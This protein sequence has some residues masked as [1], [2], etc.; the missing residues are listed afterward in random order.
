MKTLLFLFL[1]CA[2]FAQEFTVTPAGLASK[3]DPSK[4]Y[5]VVH[6]EGVSADSLYASAKRYVQSKYTGPKD[7]IKGEL[8]SQFI[9]FE[10]TSDTIM[11]VKEKNKTVAYN[12]T[13]TTTID[14][15]DGKI[16]IS[17]PA[18]D[19]YTLN[20]SGEKEAYP[21]SAYWNKSGKLVN[22]RSKKLVEAYFNAFT[23]SLIK[24]VNSG[25]NKSQIGSAEW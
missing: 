9:S 1:S 10:T 5:V 14:F 11:S 20:K 6:F 23:G 13:Y 15:K 3:T 25:G 4:T 18:V 17:F 24:G 22:S 21:F 8:P 19:I 16:R 12:A 2:C 7:A